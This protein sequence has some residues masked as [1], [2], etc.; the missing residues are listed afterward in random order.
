MSATPS[1]VSVVIPVRNA[2]ATLLDALQSV[3]QQGYRPLELLICDDGSTDRSVSIAETFLA[4][5]AG[6]TGRLLPAGG[7]GVS[8]ARNVGIRSAEGAFIAFLDSDDSWAPN[9]LARCIGA[10]EQSG[11]DLVC[12]SERWRDEDGREKIVH[13]SSLFDSTLPPG[14]ALLR[15]NAFSTSAVTVRRARLLELGD[16]PFDEEIPSAEDYDLWIRLVCLPGFRVSFLDEPLGVYLVRGGSESSRVQ[17]RHAALLQIGRRA[18]TGGAGVAPV[19]WREYVRFMGKAY[20]SCGVRY[21]S[22]GR[23]MRGVAMMVAGLALWPF[24][25][26]WIT[27]WIKRR[28]A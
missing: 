23:R 4:T 16:R 3:T 5:A 25:L 15:H 10:L 2:E 19:P 26:D 27:L 6:I 7:R 12:H 24:R 21:V 18:R 9:K 13:Y 20:V 14:I 1:L 22:I 8:H 11:A 28:R 17:R